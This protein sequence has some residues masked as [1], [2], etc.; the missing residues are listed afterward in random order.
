MTKKLLLSSVLLQGG[1]GLL[2][3]SAGAQAEPAKRSQSGQAPQKPA[4]PTSTKQDQPVVREKTTVTTQMTTNTRDKNW[5][6]DGPIFLRSADPEPP[7]AL[8][9]KNNF[10]WE[11]N[12]STSKDDDSSEFFYE[13]EL[14][15]GL[16]ENHELIFAM[17]FQVGDGNAQGNGN[18][19][20]GWHWRLWEEDGNL[21]AFAIRNIVLLGT[22]HE[23]KSADYTLKGLFTRTLVPGSTRLHVNPFLSTI[24]SDD[25][26]D[27][28]ILYPPFIYTEEEQ[29]K[30]DFRWGVA[31]GVD[32]WLRENLL[33]IV[34]YR[35]ESSEYEGN[36]DQHLAEVGLDWHVLAFTAGVSVIVGLVFGLTPA[37][38]AG[39]VDVIDSP[40][41]AVTV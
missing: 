32:H 13:V 11:T 10:E 26:D 3:F 19:E 35:Y 6:I 39:K 37:V 4:S 16:V 31:V 33:L 12:K 40:A 18:I 8:V 29:D 22:G 24:N 28:E 34:D 14:E 17:P 1:L 38:Q 20:L 21:P 30:R 5:E 23:S 15:Y 7:G 2:L 41:V 25:S 36:R 27:D 9:L